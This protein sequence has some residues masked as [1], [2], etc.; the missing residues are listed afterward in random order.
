MKHIRLIVFAIFWLGISWQT[1]AQFSFIKTDILGPFVNNPFSI[2]YERNFDSANSFGIILEGGWYMRDNATKNGQPYWDKKITG[3]GG[4]LEYRRYLQ[5]TGRMSRPVGF[6]TGAYARAINST[7]EQDF[8]TSFNNLGEIDQLEDVLMIGGGAILGYKYKKPYNPLFFEVLGGIGWGS[9][10][11]TKYAPDD[12]PAQYFLWR[13][14][15][16]IGFAF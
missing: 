12:L 13:W 2:G 9:A 15:V 3:Y 1:T 4:M 16:A 11:L 8:A 10:N 6:F 7:Y 14:E 5:Y